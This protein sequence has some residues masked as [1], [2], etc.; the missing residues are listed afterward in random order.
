M[1][2]RGY[3]RYLESRNCQNTRQDCPCP[4]PLPPCPPP[5]PDGSTGPSGPPGPPGEK[6]DKG[7]KGDTGYQG[8]T[9]PKGDNGTAGG[10]V[11]FMNIDEQVMVNSIKF[12]NIDNELY[13]SCAPTIKSVMVTNDGVGTAAPYVIIPGGDI[14]SGEEVQFAVIPGLLS[15]NIIPPGVWD[16][17]LW[18]R[19]PD[20]NIVSLQWTA[21]FQDETGTYTPNPFG[22]VTARDCDDRV[23][24]NST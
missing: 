8:P 10:I 15:S 3:Q 1:D 13:E 24:D 18:V 20:P 4:P 16:M 17:H 22:R 12:F 9:G 5:C 7:D 19:T 2:S 23:V 14:V 21:Y 11:L 6:G